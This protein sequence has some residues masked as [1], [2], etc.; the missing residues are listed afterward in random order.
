MFDYNDN[1]KGGKYF[2]EK[3]GCDYFTK[4]L[5][6]LSITVIIRIGDRP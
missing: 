2:R 4:G 1:K 5:A 3:F 6:E